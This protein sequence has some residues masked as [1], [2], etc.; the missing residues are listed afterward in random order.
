M[1]EG[2]LGEID[3]VRQRADESLYRELHFVYVHDRPEAEGHEREAGGRAASSI[4]DVVR[5]N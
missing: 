2:R 3:L 1:F 5:E 4:I